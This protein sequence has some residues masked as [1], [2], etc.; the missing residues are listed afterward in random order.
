MW[1]EIEKKNQPK[2]TDRVNRFNCSDFL[3]TAAFYVMLQV[4]QNW[5]IFKIEIQIK[6]EEK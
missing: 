5:N 1:M 3:I 6:K 2:A 4:Q